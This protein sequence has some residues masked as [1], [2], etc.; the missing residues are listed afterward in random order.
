MC[1]LPYFTEASPSTFPFNHLTVTF[2]TGKD[3]LNSILFTPLNFLE[4]ASKIQ[5][6]NDWK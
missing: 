6:L 2:V 3:N 5:F 1:K 4:K